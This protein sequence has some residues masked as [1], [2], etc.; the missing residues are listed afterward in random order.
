MK[1][2]SPWWSIDTGRELYLYKMEITNRIDCSLPPFPNM[3]IVLGTGEEVRATCRVYIYPDHP[4]KRTILCEPRLQTSRV[5]I[6]ASGRNE[7]VMW[8]YLQQVK[9]L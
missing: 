4:N 3:Q 1:E 8:T 7:S 6:K 5:K 9:T 2:E